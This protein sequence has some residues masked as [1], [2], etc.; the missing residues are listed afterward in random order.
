MSTISTSASSGLSE[1]LG[2][3]RQFSRTARLYLLHI[4]GKDL[5]HGTWDVLF[6]LY[7]LALFAPTN[8]V[9]LFG[10]HVAAIEF[11]GL[12]LAVGPVASGIGALPAGLLSDRI[13]RATNVLG[14]A[15]MANGDYE[16]PFLVAAVCYL[17]STALFWV[18]FRRLEPN[19]VAELGLA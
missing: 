4:I 15:W 13:G 14:S 7:L 19:V 8:G 17:A 16:S 5:I 18:F 6:N 12:R 1:Y 3:V 2:A 10:H 9:S 11:V